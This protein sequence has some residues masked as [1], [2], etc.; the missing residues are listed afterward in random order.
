MRKLSTFPF[1][2]AVTLAMSVLLGGCNGTS[3]LRA[4]NGNDT[5][6]LY[7]GFGNYNRQV[8]TNSRAAQKWFDQGMQLLYG[9]NHDEAIRSFREAAR[10]DPDCAMAWWGVSYA[11]GLHINNPAMTDEQS[12]NGYEAA[13]KAIAALNNETPVERALVR[14]VATRYAWPAPED[15]RALDEAYAAA[16]EQA[17]RDHP[18]DADVAALFAESLM[19]LQ[20]WDYWTPTGEPKGRIETIVAT[21]ERAMEI[22]PYHPGANHFYIHAVEASRTPDRAVEAATRLANL[23]PGSGHLVH[24]PSHIWIR[25][26][27]YADAAD[28]NVRAITADK[29]YFKKAPPPRFYNLYYVHNVHFLAYA[30]MFE[31]RY[32]AAMNAARQLDREVPMDF[33]RAFAP[34]ADGITPVAWHVMVRFGKWEDILKEPEAEEFRMISRATRLYARTVAL[35]ALGRVEEAR[36][37]MQAFDA[38]VE[39]N[40][41]DEWFIG[42]NPA[43]TALGIARKM[44]EGEILYREGELD[45]AFALLREAVADEETLVY[46]EPPGWMQPIRHALGALLLES[47]RAADAEDVYRAD[48]QRHPENGWSLLGLRNALNAQKRT[49][50]AHAVAERLAKAWTRADVSPTASCYCAQG[51]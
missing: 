4:V 21:L 23:V 51:G 3:S 40:I 48:L 37:E 22:D 42:N 28:A 17:W 32:E 20:P 10:L 27:R 24:M 33:L 38:F 13:T 47:G 12:L 14:A 50:E 15:R 11:H 5:P 1:V 7:S 49:D 9:F 16:M 8:T 29:A 45:A 31:G 18:D 44:M 19:N 36:S 26:G 6:R 41:T 25:V 46:D 34:L 35:A 43:R 2:I 30:S 39:A